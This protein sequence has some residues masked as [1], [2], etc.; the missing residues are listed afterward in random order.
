VSAN[1]IAVNDNIPT[2]IGHATLAT[3]R[4]DP[5]DAARLSASE[6]I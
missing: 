6:D 3:S 1:P 2:T 5:D 4:N